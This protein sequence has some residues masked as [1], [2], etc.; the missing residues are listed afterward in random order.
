MVICRPSLYHSAIHYS[1]FEFISFAFRV[2]LK[3]YF[4]SFAKSFFYCKFSRTLK[5]LGCILNFLL[6]AQMG[7]EHSRWNVFSACAKKLEILCIIF[8]HRFNKKNTLK[9]YMRMFVFINITRNQ[10]LTTYF[11]SSSY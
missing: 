5:M 7:G 2:L 8:S 11:Y 9:A 4:I 3:N 10:M 1:L 6:L